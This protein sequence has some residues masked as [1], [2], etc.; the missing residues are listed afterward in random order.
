M[1]YKE[2]FIG[3]IHR[4]HLTYIFN[5]NLTIDE[6]QTKL[7]SGQQ[8]SQIF[9]KDFSENTCLKIALERITEEAIFSIKRWPAKFSTKVYNYLAE[10]PLRF[11]ISKEIIPINDINYPIQIKRLSVYIL[12]NGKF[13]NDEKLKIKTLHTVGLRNIGNLLVLTPNYNLMMNP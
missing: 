10:L 3:R 9:E 6:V 1:I 7:L 8:I 12:L 2:Y 11:R 13:T 4:S 5:E